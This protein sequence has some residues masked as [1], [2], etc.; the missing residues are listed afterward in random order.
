[1]NS[2]QNKQYVSRSLF[3]LFFLLT[4]LLSSAVA[5]ARC[6]SRGLALALVHGSFPPLSPPTPQPRRI[7][8][9]LAAG[10]CERSVL[11]DTSRYSL[12]REYGA[13]RARGSQNQSRAGYISESLALQSVRSSAKEFLEQSAQ[14]TC[15]PRQTI[16]RGTTRPG[17]PFGK[18]VFT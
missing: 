14:R 18:Q 15:V 13:N 8:R 17:H 6:V 4:S 7:G 9:Y 11:Q 16:S 2:D 1:M 5:D 12:Q 3:F 10:V